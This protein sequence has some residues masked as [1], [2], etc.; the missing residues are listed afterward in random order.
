MRRQINSAISVVYSTIRLFCMKLF[1]GENLRFQ[2]LQRISPNVVIELEKKGKLILG[3]RT[4]IHSG[5]KLKV[6]KNAEIKLDDRV[7]LNYGCMLICRDSI[8][9][10]EGTMFGPN[11]LVYDHDHN[12]SAENGL[13]RKSYTTAPVK[14]GSNCWIGANTVI[15][16]G[17]T[18]GNNAVI[19]AGSVVTKDIPERTIM[20]QK[21]ECFYHEM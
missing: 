9:I 10:G 12:I 19:G 8:Q 21:R 3:R 15:L 5:C 2:K 16:K 6:R 11:V 4:S 7:F 14:I 20:V 18:I 13:M 17:V 1:H